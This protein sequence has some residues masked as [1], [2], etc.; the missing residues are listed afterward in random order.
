MTVNT[1]ILGFGAVLLLVGILGGGFEIKEFKV[2]KVGPA[3]R[4]LSTVAGAF[5][6]ILGVG[7]QATDVSARGGADKNTYIQ[8]APNVQPSPNAQSSPVEFTIFDRVDGNQ[9]T[10]QVTVLIDGRVK[11]QLTVDR[12]NPQSMLAI[13]VPASG[14]YSYTIESKTVVAQE[15]R[16]YEYA[17][18]GQG[19]INVVDG[20]RFDLALT[21]SGNTWLVTLVEADAARAAANQQ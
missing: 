1:V 4:V 5:F 20:K 21:S 11:G 9:V 19:I 7:L 6:V 3:P 10:E 12:Q 13:T 2:P 14:R 15:G 16:F 18:A 8:P 17:G